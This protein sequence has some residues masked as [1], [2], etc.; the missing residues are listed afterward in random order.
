MKLPLK[1]AISFCTTC[2]N[3]LW[4]IKSTLQD[5]LGAISNSHEIV[6]IDYGSTDGLSEWVWGEFKAFIGDKKLI[7]FEV[8]NEVRWSVSRAKNLAHRIANGEYLFNLDAD[9]YLTKEDIALINQSASWGLPCHQ[10]SGDMQD[11]SYGRIGLP[12]HLFEKIGGYDET[13]LPMGYQDVDL[14]ERFKRLPTKLAKLPPPSK[15]AVQNNEHHK[16]KEFFALDN[17]SGKNFSKVY[18]DSNIMNAQFSKF[19]LAT[20]GPIR[21]GGGFSYRGLL[22]GQEIIIDGFNNIRY[23]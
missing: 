14:L 15:I 17:Q 23:I 12:K 21:L 2:R 7:F 6:L 9:N 22:N 13:L 20:E 8:K 4:Q 19:K 3:R 18:H 16:G 5:N 1:N 10:F 11:G